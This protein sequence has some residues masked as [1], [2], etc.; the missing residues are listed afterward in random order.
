MSGQRLGQRR[1]RRFGRSV[2]GEHGAVFAVPIKPT[3]GGAALRG[4]LS[5]HL[6]ESR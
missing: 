5:L 2:F 6:F 1:S 4:D 3:P